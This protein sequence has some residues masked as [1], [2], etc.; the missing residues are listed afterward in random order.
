MTSRPASYVGAMRRVYPILLVLFGCGEASPPRASE[1]TPNT[2]SA[3]TSFVRVRAPA[4]EAILEAPAHALPDATSVERISATYPLRVTRVHVAAGDA[5]EVGDAIVSV[6][7]QDVFA[8]AAEYQ[9]TAQ[10]LAGYRGRL[11]EVRALRADGLVTTERV[12]EL[13][14]E[15]RALEATMRVAQATIRAAGLSPMDASRAVAQSAITLRAHVTG[16]VRTL[17]VVPGEVRMDGGTF[18]TIVGGRSRRVEARFAAM[19]PRGV[20]F[21]FE[22][23]AGVRTPLPEVPLRTMEG[24][25]RGGVVVWFDLPETTTIAP[26][27]EGHVHVT[28]GVPSYLEV[29]TTALVTI[30]GATNVVRRRNG[31]EAFVPVVVSMA[32]GASAIVQGDLA[33]TDEVA[34]DGAASNL[35]R[36]R[37]DAP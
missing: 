2:T 35:V 19:P 20:R 13:E 6:S 4:D 15:A 16:V 3:A 29:P 28:L 1:R 14:R 24:G 9:G 8:A 27:T 10:R 18:A 11:D 31:R 5:V 26:Y 22:D 33:L 30:D 12:F 32:S 37:S 34:A 17:E 7:S 36:A 21:A 25:E 23:L